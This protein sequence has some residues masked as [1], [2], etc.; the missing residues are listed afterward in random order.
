[1]NGREHSKSQQ[2]LETVID[3]S[4]S[5]ISMTSQE[6]K[7]ILI[8]KMDPPL[9][10]NSLHSKNFIYRNYEKMM[11]FHQIFKYDKNYVY[12][13]MFYWT[14]NDSILK[15][16]DGKYL[17]L[18]LNLKIPEDASVF[19]IPRDRQ[20]LYSRYLVKELLMHMHYA[21]DYYYNISPEY[22]KFLLVK[23]SKKYFFDP[24]MIIMGICGIKNLINTIR[25]RK[26]VSKSMLAP[27]FY[28]ITMCSLTGIHRYLEYVSHY[29][30]MAKEIL[31]QHES[32]PL[33]KEYQD[34]L[35]YKSQLYLYERDRVIKTKTIHPVKI[36]DDADLILKSIKPKAIF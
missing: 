18:E 21:M 35:I 12:D 27:L 7:H 26:F 9:F 34:Y 24:A 3:P 28:Y 32:I 10:P 36:H 11:L 14:Y 23:E 4:K 1:M 25:F 8:R 29:T 30:F 33:E 13:P 31:Q 16:F 15:S 19:P 2:N 17:E 5:Q 6:S 22:K 20:I